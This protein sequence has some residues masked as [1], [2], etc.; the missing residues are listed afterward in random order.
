[1]RAE[2]RAAPGEILGAAL[3]HIDAPAVRAQQVRGE[4]AG[5]RATDDQRAGLAHTSSGHGT[6]VDLTVFIAIASATACPTPS[7]VKG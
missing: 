2:P 1:M 5:E 4:H 6:M 3:V 7:S